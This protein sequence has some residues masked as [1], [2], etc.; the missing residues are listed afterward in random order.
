MTGLGRAHRRRLGGR[1]ARAM[2]SASRASTRWRPSATPD[3]ARAL[4]ERAGARDSAG[5]EAEAEPLY[6][7]ALEAGSTSTAGRRR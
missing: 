6:R 2:R 1:R 5:I 7:Q 3:D 4:F